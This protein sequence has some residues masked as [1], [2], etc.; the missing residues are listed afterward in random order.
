[1]GD[2]GVQFRP[3]ESAGI[4]VARAH[5]PVFI[6]ARAALVA[7]SGAQMIL[8]AAAPASVAQLSAGHG[9]K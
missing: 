5:V 1:M 7:E 4:A 9:E 8:F 3:H 6:E 2:V